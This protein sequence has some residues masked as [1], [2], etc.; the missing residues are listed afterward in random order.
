M[1]VP[2]SLFPQSLSKFSLV[3]L[4]A[5]HPPLHTPYIY[6]PNHCLL[7]A[8]YARIIAA[9]FAVVS[10]LCHLILVSL[11][12]LLRILYCGFVRHIRLT[13]LISAH[14]SATL[15]SFLMGHVS[16][17]WN[18]VLRTQPLYN[19]RLTFN[20]TLVGNSTNC[21]NLLHPFR[22]LFSAAASAFPSTLN[23]SAGRDENG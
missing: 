14:W 6:S 17:P 9:C 23:M 5:W 13:I 15:F 16:L 1:H 18:I 12:P 22:I 7:F 11:Y 20:D 19:V 4:F 21:L 2:D 8:T 10:R 3:Y